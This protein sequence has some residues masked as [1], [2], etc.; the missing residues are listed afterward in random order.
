MVFIQ[1]LK[2]EDQETS[3][4]GLQ[5]ASLSFSCERYEISPPN[6][7]EN[8]NKAITLI[9]ND[10]IQHTII[11]YAFS[12]FLSPGMFVFGARGTGSPMLS[13]SNT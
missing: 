6:E 1:K 13:G 9:D 12:L 2:L 5:V 3:S 7:T 11:I 8:T 10:T 4:P